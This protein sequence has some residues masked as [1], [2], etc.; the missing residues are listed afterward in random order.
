MTSIYLSIYLPIYL[1]TTYLELCNGNRYVCVL[2]YSCTQQLT[3]ANQHT[4]EKNVTITETKHLLETQWK[5]NKETEMK[6][7]RAKQQS[8]QLQQDFKEQ[9]K[10]CSR[11]KDEV[12]SFWKLFIIII[13]SYRKSL[14]NTFSS[15]L[16]LNSCKATWDRAI[17]ESESVKSKISR[18]ERDCKENEEKSVKYYTSVPIS[19]SLILILNICLFL[20]ELR[21]SESTMLLWKRSLKL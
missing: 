11:L 8:V 19:I 10:R 14:G 21:T 15:V 13:F 1:S 7:S 16:Q 3:Q 12:R 2:F 5:N 6:V 18:M 4:R 9:E 17:S 20:I